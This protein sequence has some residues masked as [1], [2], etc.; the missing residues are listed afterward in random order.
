MIE[1]L[2]LGGFTM[3]VL[4]F[5]SILGVAVIIDRGIYF[6][7]LRSPHVN[8]LTKKI[9]NLMKE[10][11]I[12]DAIDICKKINSPI[13]KTAEKIIILI[14]RKNHTDN[15][16]VNDTI[17]E[18]ILENELEMERNMWLLNISAKVSP[19]AGLLGTVTGM[20]KSFSVIAVEGVGNPLLL[21]EGIS[22]ALITTATGLSVAIPCLIMYNLFTSRIE[23]TT[24]RSEKLCTKL[25]N[26]TRNLEKSGE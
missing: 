9:E 2:R 22:Q 20:I 3:Y 24:T 23:R 15:I 10:Q 25:L 18:L 12:N 16:Y 19:L 4:L 7:R 17:K 11:N 13:L 8:I 26:I 14:Q 1:Y 5:L 21:A 6:L